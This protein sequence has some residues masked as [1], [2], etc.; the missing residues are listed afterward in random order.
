MWSVVKRDA[1]FRRAILAVT[2]TELNSP[3]TSGA[4]LTDPILHF[5]QL[6][7]TRTP[8]LK[9]VC[10]MIEERNRRDR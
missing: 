5:L 3:A 2:A 6:K 9:D 8:I 4:S 1:R 7:E 10:K